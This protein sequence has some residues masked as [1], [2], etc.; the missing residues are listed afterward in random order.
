MSGI[1]LDVIVV[2]VAVLLL[3]FGLWR[4]M[5]KMIFGLVSSLL[6]LI[7]T[8]V[9]LSTVTGFVVD[10]TTLDER[11]SDAID[12]PL[13]EAIP[14]GDVEINFYDLD[15]NGVADELGF[16]AD[17]TPQPFSELLKGSNFALFSGVIEGVI[18]GHI[19]KDSPVGVRFADVLSSTLVGYIIMAIVFVALLIIFAILV[20]ILMSLIKKLVTRTYLG[21]FV[22]KLFGAVLGLVVAMVIIWGSLA[23]IRLLGTYE[24]II[25]VNNVIEDSTITK[26]LFNNNIIYNFLVNSFNIKGVIDG[27]LSGMGGGKG[28][29]TAESV[30]AMVKAIVN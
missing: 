6:A 21:H 12:K 8:I 20:R 14:N 30:S 11:L 25:P 5:Y 22:D 7:L 29:E 1:L 28:E 16:M 2:V 13:L 10:K 18:S 26:F 17:G 27:I 19:E 4:G 24:W 23:V 9:L 3:I 15:G